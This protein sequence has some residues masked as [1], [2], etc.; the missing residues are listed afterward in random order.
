MTTKK[1][2]KKNHCRILL[3]LTFSLTGEKLQ[4]LKDQVRPAGDSG[5]PRVKSAGWTGLPC[6]HFILQLRKQNANH[7]IRSQKRQLYKGGRI[8]YHR[9]RQEVF[10]SQDVFQQAEKAEGYFFDDDWAA[11]SLL[12]DSIN[13]L[14]RFLRPQVD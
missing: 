4:G 13:G 5:E 1:R 10:C 14:T 9:R 12:H 11:L 3:L 7:L 2:K 6:L 8:L